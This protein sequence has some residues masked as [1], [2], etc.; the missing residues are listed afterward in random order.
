MFATY[1]HQE[2]TYTT[3][4]VPD[5]VWVGK[6][7]LH[8]S[9]IRRQLAET[10]AAYPSLPI[11]KAD[12]EDYTA[13]HNPNYLAKIV[14]QSQ[15]QEVE[16]P[17]RLN[18]ECNGFPYCLPGYLYSLGG[19]MA[20]VDAF[21]VGTLKRAFTFSLGGH[22]AFADRG[23]GY[24]MLNPQAAVARYAQRQGFKNILII[25]WDIH[26]GDGTQT[27]FEGDPTVHT[28]SIHSLADLY[29]GKASKLELGSTGY[30]EQFGHT[31]VPL[32]HAV[33]EPD[34]FNHLSF[35][36][37]FYRAKESIQAFT[38]ALHNL[39]FNPDL[40]IIFAGCDAHQDDCGDEITDWREDDFRTLTTTMLNFAIS[41]GCPV[42]STQGGGYQLPSTIASTV[43]H[44]ETLVT[45]RKDGK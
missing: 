5:S 4:Q 14:A 1:L 34:L 38:D 31:N 30:G 32:L 37:R 24:C 41:H 43:V 33:Y 16:E 44:V 19:M 8:Y 21:R 18:L 40:I 42:L 45:Y 29:M 6:S 17:P 15:D 25:D 22:H 2:T 3:K 23:H 9:E 36:T 7:Y 20:A 35:S 10:L 39:D 27:I 13:V 12:L 11:R 28:F 26:H